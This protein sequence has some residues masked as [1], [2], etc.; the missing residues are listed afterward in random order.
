MLN[1][2]NYNYNLDCLMNT[3]HW[4]KLFLITTFILYFVFV[5]ITGKQLLKEQHNWKTWGNFASFIMIIV[6][7]QWKYSIVKC[8]NLE[9]SSFLILVLRSW[10]PMGPRSQ[11]AQERYL[12]VLTVLVKPRL[13]N[14]NMSS[15]RKK[16][17]TVS[18]TPAESFSKLSNSN[19]FSLE[20]LYF[21]FLLN[22]Y[23]W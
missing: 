5:F 21:F 19:S 15:T 6:L 4:L 14:I 22:C 16:F 7:K 17:F 3:Y 23:K 20:I 8:V 13:S 1:Q 9:I 2:T 10:N 11:S 12:V 18:F